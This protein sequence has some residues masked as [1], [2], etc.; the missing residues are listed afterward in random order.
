MFSPAV[1][2]SDFNISEI[3]VLYIVNLVSKR[4][5]HDTIRC[6]LTLFRTSFIYLSMLTL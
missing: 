5:C 2:L 3:H 1:S 4:A 6:T